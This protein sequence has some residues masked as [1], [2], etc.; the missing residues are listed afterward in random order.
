[1]TA[2]KL[3][4]PYDWDPELTD[5]IELAITPPTREPV[6]TDWQPAYRDTVNGTR[7]VWIRPEPQG[8]KV[9]V[10]LRDRNGVRQHM[11]ISL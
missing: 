4:V 3:Q 6:E 10:W 11:M 5:L 7:V 2:S 8:A 1:M 9:L